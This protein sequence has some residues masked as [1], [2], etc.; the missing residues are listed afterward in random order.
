MSHCNK[1][2]VPLVEE[3]KRRVAIFK[4][5]SQQQEKVKTIDIRSKGCFVPKA[6]VGLKEEAK[7]AAT[8][9]LQESKLVQFVIRKEAEVFRNI[10]KTHLKK[11]SPVWI[12][13]RKKEN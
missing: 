13:P 7:Y 9:R 3:L 4:A 12:V 1:E 2:N 5:K 8:P 11:I 6:L 10:P